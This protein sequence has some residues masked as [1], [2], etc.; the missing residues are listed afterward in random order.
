MVRLWI[1]ARP[2]SFDAASWHVWFENVALSV[3]GKQIPSVTSNV[4]CD[5]IKLGFDRLY[6]HSV[7][8]N[9]HA[10]I[11]AIWNQDVS[12][13]FVKMVDASGP[14]NRSLRSREALPVD[15]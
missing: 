15:R 8:Q 14:V 3:R 11:V 12:T 1:F 4:Q 2:P 13:W 6:L 7:G 9:Q 10:L 5:D